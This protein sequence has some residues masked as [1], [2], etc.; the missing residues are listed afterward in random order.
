MGTLPNCRRN[1]KCGLNIVWITIFVI[2]ILNSACSRLFQT[3][4]RVKYLGNVDYGFL[5][6]LVWSPDGKKI[7]VTTHN[8]GENYSKIYLFDIGTRKFEQVLKT[9]YGSITAAGWS[10][11]EEQLLFYSDDG[12]KD[13]KPG[14]WILDLGGNSAP[15]FVYEGEAAAWSPDGN[16]L[17]FFKTERNSP[18]WD[19]T[20]HILDLN[21]FEDRIIYQTKGRYRS[22]LSWSPD[23]THLA[24]ALVQGTQL[25]V[26]NIYD[27][28]IVNGELIQLTTSG[29]NFFSTW[30][31]NGDLVAYI[32]ENENGDTKLRIQKSNGSCGTDVL[33]S[34][35]ISSPS[36][37]PDGRSIAF[38]GTLG[39][40][41]QLDLAKALGEQFL[42]DGLVCP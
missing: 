2:V 16:T 18:A 28:N 32:T 6:R 3:D 9:S 26:V 24:L 31:P 23:G 19:V 29:K 30:S 25:D 42:S 12:G 38:I 14:I 10:P 36:W 11:N 7:A 21:S 15:E 17:A 37:S 22:G 20:L 39:G 5:S 33:S 41:Y 34:D 4:A 1:M 13:F 8:E 40:I 27:L 35:Y